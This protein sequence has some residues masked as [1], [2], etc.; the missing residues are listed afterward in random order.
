MGIQLTDLRPVID[1]IIFD[2]REHNYGLAEKRLFEFLDDLDE[3]QRELKSA[4]ARLKTHEPWVNRHSEMLMNS[5]VRF[6][7]E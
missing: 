5:P 2:L 3:L 7:E 1:Q 6:K 4:Y